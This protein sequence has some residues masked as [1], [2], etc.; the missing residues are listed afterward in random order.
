M[1]TTENS[2]IEDLFKLL[3]QES[4]FVP[5]APQGG[6]LPGYEP[7]MPWSRCDLDY[8]RSLVG[9]DLGVRLGAPSGGLC[10]VEFRTEAG[11]K[12]FIACNPNM[13][14]TLL[15]RGPVS[16]SVWLRVLDAKY[17][18]NLQF[19]NSA[20]ISDGIK[21]FYSS[22]PRAPYIFLNQSQPVRTFFSNIVWGDPDVQGC[23]EYQK[24]ALQYPPVLTSRTG[25]RSTNPWFAVARFI[26]EW[27]IRF[28]PENQTF[29]SF[30][31]GKPFEVPRRLV[32]SRPC[33]QSG[34]LLN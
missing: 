16:I 17:P 27:P 1:K 32:L 28:D 29:Y 25:K 22:S 6:V 13:E 4:V 26:A 19:G 12:D 15:S 30:H 11:Y 3:G 7:L 8:R 10:V 23:M 21:M 14:R 20:W 33:P 31:E 2:Y 34:R 9:K 18:P 5:V 24:V